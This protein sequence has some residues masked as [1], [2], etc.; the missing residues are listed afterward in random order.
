VVW[1]LAWALAAGPVPAAE[2][3]KKDQHGNL[4]FRVLA[5]RRDE[6]AALDAARKFFADGKDHAARKAELARRA[7]NGEPPPPVPVDTEFGSSYSWREIG[8]TGLRMLHLDPAFEK[9]PKRAALLRKQAAA[10]REKGETFLVGG[11]VLKG[12]LLYSRECTNKR[13]PEAERAKKKYDYFL[14]A[15]DP[16]KGQALTG[17]YLTDVRSGKSATG[18]SCVEFVFD[19]KGS[20]VLGEL[21]RSRLP[22]KETSPQ[23]RYLAVI[24]DGRI[25]MAVPLPAPGR[26]RTVLAAPCPAEEVQGLLETLRDGLPRK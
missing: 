1:G 23:T 18:G 26:G 3:G 14:L 13:L 5:N 7:E 24:R 6:P 15:R 19:R 2:E 22:V 8:P 10:A 25:V 17:E 9:D 4:T 11:E 21:A 16:D 12:C 20:Q